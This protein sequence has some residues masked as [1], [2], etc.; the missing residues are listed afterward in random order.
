MAVEVTTQP[1]FALGKQKVLFEGLDQPSAGTLPN[2][3][4][5]SDG[6]RFLMLKPGEQ[7][8]QAVT[9]IK[10]VLNCFE[11]LKKKVPTGK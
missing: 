7:Q 6:H 11:E 10:V 5:S 1:T 8:Q 3:D 9:Q 2:Y 4:V